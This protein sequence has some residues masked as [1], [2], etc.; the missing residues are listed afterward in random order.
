MPLWPTT[1]PR[2]ALAGGLIGLALAIGAEATSIFALGNV[3]TVIPGRV[4]RCAQPSPEQLA[5]LVRRYNVHT[6]VNL[7]GYCDGFDWYLA[8]CRATRDLDL[9]QEDVTFSAG[10]L[11]PPT[12]LRRLVDV[13]DHTEYPIVIHCRQGVDRTGLTAA[14]ALLLYTDAGLSEARRQLS[15]RYSHVSLG[16]MAA[17]QRFFDL[18]A[19][20][21][22]GRPHAPELFR[23]WATAEYCPGPERGRLEL[24]DLPKLKAGEPASVRVRAVNTS[25]QPWQLLPGTGAGIHVEYKVIDGQDGVKQTDHAGLFRATVAPGASVDLTLVLNGLPAGRYLLYADLKDGPDLEFIQVGGEP[26]TCE[27]V[28]E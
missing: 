7:R 15:F 20:W 28:V 21:L 24:I 3:H 17:M 14:V 13:L 26:L 25:V 19:E 6:V 4:Y 1:T 8:E 27:L 5:D 16:R 23:R 11:P 22:S 2:A 12:E 9:A 10:R 18:Y